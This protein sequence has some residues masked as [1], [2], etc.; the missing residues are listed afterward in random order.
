MGNYIETATLRFPRATKQGRHYAVIA[1]VLIVGSVI[2]LGLF[3]ETRSRE[4]QAASIEFTKGSAV[5]IANLQA[6]LRQD[7]LVTEAVQAFFLSSQNVS[8][9]DFNA[10][11]FPF[12]NHHSSIC[13][14]EWVP[15]VRASELSDYEK[16]AA[17]EGIQKYQVVERDR[18]GRATAVANRDEYYPIFYVEPAGANVASLGF[19]LATDSAC[20]AA[21][22]QARDTGQ[23]AATGKVPLFDEGNQTGVRLFYPVYR[24]T[25]PVNSVNDRRQALEGFVVGVL[26]I[27]ELVGDSLAGLPPGGIDILLNDHTNKGR[28]Q[29]LFFHYSRTRGTG[30]AEDFSRAGWANHLDV[31]ETFEVAGRGW[32]VVCRPAPHFLATTNTWQPWTNATA[33]LLLTT[34]LASYLFRSALHNGRMTQLASQL[35]LVN[36]RLEHEVADRKRLDTELRKSKE[37]AELSTVAKS[38]FLA[39]MSH[40]IRTPMTSILGYADLLA[41]P[42]LGPSSRQ[43]YLAVIRRSGEHLLMIINDILDLS[44][45]E[46][47]RLTLD[48]Q[49]CSVVSLLADVASVVRPRAEQRGV[50]LTVEYPGPMPESIITD[51]ARLRQAV[52]NL[53]GNA[54]KFTEQGSVRIVATFLAAW[55]GVE[56]AVKIEVIDTGVGIREEMLPKLFQPFSQG[57][58]SVYQKFGGTGLGLA[59]SHEIAR[60]LGGELTAKSR[61]G[62]GSTF[63]LILPTGNIKDVAMLER[64]LEAA[65]DAS[66][67]HW[68]LPMVDLQGVRILLAEDGYDNRELIQTV[69]RQAGAV[70]ESVENGRLAVERAQADSFD[71][72]LMDMNM[73]EMDGLSAT[74]IL[75]HDGYVQPI[76]ALTANAMTADV[77]RCRKAGCNEHLAKPINRLQLIHT[78]ASYAGR[79]V[80]EVAVE[81]P[82]PVSP[83]QDETSGS[84]SEMAGDPEMAE[85]LGDFVGHLEERVVELREAREGEHYDELKQY[86]HRLKGAGG[87]YGYPALSQAAAVLEEAAKVAD[88]TGTT[89]ALEAVA[90][91]CQTI[92]AVHAAQIGATVGS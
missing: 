89:A 65:H 43:N 22:N 49:P 34:L 85:I 73:P 26:R 90:A 69:L 32:T 78:I 17:R 86:A 3:L 16:R 91:L 35:S 64:P 87:S 1:A 76:L 15:C 45:I 19:D 88:P 20:L 21:M 80:P 23:P 63:T 60:L 81:S 27:R 56:P 50:L 59:I 46:A 54:V 10:F 92:Q 25:M 61:I 12:V 24:K 31:S 72:I 29:Q 2:S 39:T 4:R 77:E 55:R 42:T 8:R 41:D 33:A 40:E 5:R 37:S 70:V 11:V 6:T 66:G 74:R 52:I 68:E 53:V 13:A 79:H 30:G 48:I 58:V 18:E 14:L 28:K 84:V 44:R 51:G 9:E 47:G 62:E 71:I 7:L 75:R 38:R 82:S 83:P 67:H 36:A 57:D